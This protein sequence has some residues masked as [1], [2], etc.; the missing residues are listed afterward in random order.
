M[1]ADDNN[2]KDGDDGP[3]KPPLSTRMAASLRSFGNFLY[4][5]KDHTVMGRTALSWGKLTTVAVKLC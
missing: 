2:N 1:A 3:S 5:R 4:N